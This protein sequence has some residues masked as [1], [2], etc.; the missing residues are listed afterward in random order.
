MTLLQEAS[1][2]PL[3]VIRPQRCMGPRRCTARRGTARWSASSRRACWRLSFC[4]SDPLQNLI[5]FYG[6]GSSRLNDGIVDEGSAASAT[7]SGSIVYDAKR[8]LADVAAMV[9]RAE[10]AAGN[11]K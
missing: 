8:L 2:H 5:V 10:E 4:R 9:E 11:G 1:F 6:T 3:E 7:R